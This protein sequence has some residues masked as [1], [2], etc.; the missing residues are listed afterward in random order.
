M[1]ETLKGLIISIIAATLICAA[2]HLFFASVDYIGAAIGVTSAS[3]MVV[4]AQLI[5]YLLFGL[6][7]FIL[8]RIC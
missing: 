5:F 2:F 3:E 6:G 8:S 1:K 7:M 4:L